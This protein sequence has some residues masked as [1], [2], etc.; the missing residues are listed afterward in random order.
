MSGQGAAIETTGNERRAAAEAL[1]DLGF[2]PAPASSECP[3]KP[4]DLIGRYRLAERVGEGGFGVVWEARQEVPIRRDIALKLIKRGMDSCEIIARFEAESQTLARMDHPNIAAVLDAGTTV[5]GR[6]FFAMEL[7]RGEP[8]NSYCDSRNLSIRE[9]LELFIPV[10]LAVQHAHQKAILHRDLK[11]TN[12]LVTEVDGKPVPKVIDFGI[13]KALGAADDAAFRDSLLRTRAGT[14][15][16]TLQYMS[17][18]QAG[19][20][21]DVDTRSD[22]YSLG[23]ILYELLV[24][25]TP[26]RPEDKPGAAREEMLRRIREEEPAKP[27]SKAT[28]QHAVTRN[29]DAPRLKRQ[30]RGELDWIVLKAIE[31]DRRRRYETATALATDLRHFLDEKPVSA[32]APTWGYQA[33]KFA[34]RHRVGLAIATVVFIAL[35]TATGVSLWQTSEARKAKEIADRSRIESEMNARRAADAVEVYLNKV[36]TQS[37]LKGEEFR[38]MRRDLLE[39]ALPFYEAMVASESGD[40]QV[41]IN[42]R[43][44]LERIGTIYDDIGELEKSIAARRN[45][46]AAQEE[47]AAILPQDDEYKNTLANCANDLAT[48]LRKAGRHE[49]SSQVQK[50]AVAIWRGIVATSKNDYH[51]DLAKGLLNLADSLSGIGDHTA[52][53]EAALGAIDSLRA[54]MRGASKDE[55]AMIHEAVGIMLGRLPGKE[56]ATEET[57]RLAIALRQEIASKPGAAA[58]TIGNLAGAEHRLSRYLLAWKRWDDAL[59][60]AQRA[61]TNY[62]RMQTMVAGTADS[63]HYVAITKV[64]VGECLTALKRTEE[65]ESVL[66]EALAMKRRLGAEFPANS[67]HIGDEGLVLLALARLRESAGDFKGAAEYFCNS[68]ATYARAR[69]VNRINAEWETGVRTTSA[70]HAEM[71]EKIGDA[72]GLAAAGL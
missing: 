40:V 62:Q 4:G 15:V 53:A 26:L 29:T 67:G 18:E 47:L 69:S 6:P 44:A 51:L 27:S 57:L 66:Q 13:A 20:V 12:I 45:A 50:R 65:A 58:D 21:S 10:C 63:R 39:S 52:S 41:R 43:V 70:R 17:P 16:G 31:K 68:A 22:V 37:R 38:E 48:S 11:P 61:T 30:L 60:Y 9:R 49:E 24:G 72:A 23:I 46:L 28:A 3:D 2:N 34:L 25:N 36:T 35:A 8:L 71:L 14:I 56:G 1:L 5:D 19:S 42:R 32:A 59:S 64:S 54:S 33:S 55:L 7:V